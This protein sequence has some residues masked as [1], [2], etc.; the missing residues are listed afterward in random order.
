MRVC[1]NSFFEKIT[2]ATTFCGRGKF[3]YLGILTHPQSN[4]AI[5]NR[6]NHIRNLSHTRIIT[7]R[8]VPGDL[9]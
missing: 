9:R 2:P 6:N 5:Y 3:I 4:Q 7:M 8:C 1:Q